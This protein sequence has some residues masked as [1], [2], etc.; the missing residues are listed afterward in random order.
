MN[1]LLMFALARVSEVV[2]WLIPADFSAQ[3]N[4]TI[5]RRQEGTGL[6]LLNSNEY[7]MWIEGKEQT[8]FCPGIPGAGKTM[9]SS[10]VVD[11]LWKTFDDNDRIGISC[12]FCSYKR[13]D[14]QG[15]ADLLASLL[16]QLV[17]GRSVLPD[18]VEA[19]HERHSRMKTRPL[20]DEPSNTLQSVVEGCYSR[21]F[22][23]IDA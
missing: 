8:L 16:K 20:F 13:Q 18:V 9:M 23:V 17:Q 1:H 12:L 11:D 3:Q 10:I 19:L 21:V 15:S 22:F 6:W 14:E 4:E 7:K 2:H 5:S